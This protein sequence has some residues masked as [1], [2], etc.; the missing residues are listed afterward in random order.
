MWYLNKDANISISILLFVVVG[1]VHNLIN[2]ADVSLG[3]RDMIP[4]P[5]SNSVKNKLFE[6][7]YV[8]KATTYDVLK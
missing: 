3:R 1:H 7:S 4:K 2:V 5:K 8:S 6:N